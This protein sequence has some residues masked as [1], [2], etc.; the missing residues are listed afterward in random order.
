[1]KAVLVNLATTCLFVTPI[2]LY[3]LGRPAL[4]S[5]VAINVT[6]LAVVL[7]T[8]PWGWKLPHPYSDQRHLRR[9][10][11]WRGRLLFVAVLVALTLNAH[12]VLLSRT[13]L[14]GAL[15]NPWLVGF[16][17]WAFKRVALAVGR[18]AGI[19]V[20]THRELYA[21][22]R[23]LDVYGAP[24]SVGVVYFHPGAWVLGFRELGAAPLGV[25]NELGIAGYSVTY[26]LTSWRSSDG[27]R[28]ALA[29][30]ELAVAYVAQRH[31]K[32]VVAGDSAGGFLAFHV[33]SRRAVAAVVAGWPVC[34]VLPEKWAPDDVTGLTPR[35]AADIRPPNVYVPQSA[36]DTWDHLRIHVFGAIKLVCGRVANGWLPAS[37]SDAELRDLELGVSSAPALVFAAQNDSIVPY[38]QIRLFASAY[39][40]NNA[41]F[42]LLVFDDADHGVG[43]INSAAGRQALAAFLARHNLISSHSEVIDYA[44]LDALATLMGTNNSYARGLYRPAR[45][46]RATLHI[47][48]QAAS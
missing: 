13:L 7:V 28:D 6:F 10:V 34:T 47:P 8:P 30:A 42:S 37:C 2:A 3:V 12:Y 41:D 26:T 44:P 38:S 14:E 24:G 22:G 21:P 27:L 15:A 36:T 17:N 31:S 29:D 1:M 35:R 5:L 9:R 11:T 23:Y 18:S 33:A 4:R 19:R 16:V 46:A 32:V 45:H 43:G 20:S 39:R 48:L 40:K 25:F